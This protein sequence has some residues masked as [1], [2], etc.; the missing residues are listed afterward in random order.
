MPLTVVLVFLT[1][2]SSLKANSSLSKEWSSLF[3]LSQSLEMAVG[4]GG[5]DLPVWVQLDEEQAG[6]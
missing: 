6:S 2:L 3:K 4:E 5:G 1:F